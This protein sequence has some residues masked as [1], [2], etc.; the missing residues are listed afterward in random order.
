MHYDHLLID[1]SDLMYRS[2]FAL[3]PLTSP[4]GVPTSAITG[5]LNALDRLKKDFSG[6]YWLIFDPPTTNHRHTLYAAYKQHRKPM[7]EDLKP[8]WPLVIELLIALGYPVIQ[9]AHYEADDVIASLAT[10]SASEQQTVL[11]VSHDKDLMQ[12]VN[13]HIHIYH[14]SK[15]KRFDTASVESVWGLHPTQLRDYLTLVGDSSDGFAGVLGVGPKTAVKWLSTYGSLDHLWANREEIGG[16]VG[17]ALRT[18]AELLARNRQLA[19][20][21]DDIEFHAH[22][23]QTAPDEARAAQLLTELGMARRIPKKCHLPTHIHHA[24]EPLNIPKNGPR[25]W[26]LQTVPEGLELTLWHE[27]GVWSRVFSEDDFRLFASTLL[28]SDHDYWWDTHEIYRRGIDLP[29]SVQDV[30]LACY[31]MDSGQAIQ[32]LL[33]VW[34]RFDPHVLSREEIS[35]VLEPSAV[36]KYCAYGLSQIA[37]HLTLT[38]AYLTVERPVVRLL[39]QMEQRGILV[40]LTELK[41]LSQLLYEGMKKL[42]SEIHASCGY[43]LNILSPTQLRVWLYEELKIPTAHKTQ[44]GQWSTSEDS[45]SLLQDEYPILKSILKYRMYAKLRATYCDKLSQQ[46]DASG[47]VHSYFDQKGTITGRL[48]SR[49]PNVQNIPIR[50][51]EGRWIRR[52]FCAAPKHRLISADYSQIELRLMAHMSQDPNMLAVLRSGGDIHRQTAAWLFEEP[53]EAITEEQRRFAKTINFG[54]LYGMTAY[55]LAKALSIESTQAQTLIEKYFTAY[56]RLKEYRASLIQQ[57]HDLGYVHTYSGRRIGLERNRSQRGWMERLALNAPM[58]GSAAEIIK[59]AMI[60]LTEPIQAHRSFLL[61]QVHDELV[62]EAPEEEVS[63]L[64]EHLWTLMPQVASLSVPL[65]ISVKI[66]TNWGEMHAIST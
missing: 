7:P 50:S 44:K 11:I 15:Q 66:G 3:P 20:L 53:L 39:S 56:P 9:K 52:A 64:A 4:S 6:K 19:T 1:G 17:A 10:Q 26:Y 35:S 42:E 21:V 25:Y 8:Q 55:G 65:E 45:L 14:P 5:V 37:S 27:E 57:A 36:S 61:L 58:Q 46:A 51:E 54:L 18:S 48:S 41:A 31:A 32:D 38:P 28:W 49:E 12:L 16:K 24:W 13:D 2:Y 59:L 30:S 29:M 40:S 34:H 62:I 23:I 22:D 47:R 60:A 43:A 33:D 63:R